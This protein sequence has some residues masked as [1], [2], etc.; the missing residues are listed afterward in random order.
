MGSNGYAVLLGF[1]RFI[2]KLM[3]IFG[4]EKNFSIKESNAESK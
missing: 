1:N 2:N 4:Y 3:K